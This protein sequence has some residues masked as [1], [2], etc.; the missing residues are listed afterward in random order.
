MTKYSIGI[1]ISKSDFHASFS[2][3]D[4]KQHVK[5]IRSGTFKNNK[6]GFEAFE[7]CIKTTCSI[8]GIPVSF[9]MEATGVYYENCALFLFSKG[10]SV[11]VVL[12]NKSKNTSL[13][14]VLKLKMIRLMQGH[15]V[16]WVQSRLWKFGNQWGS[17]STA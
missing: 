13:R 2:T 11:S 17:F 5:V 9:T 12:P 16:A 10:Y 6:I 15:L 1:D 7:K 14:W 4:E 8:S 3:I